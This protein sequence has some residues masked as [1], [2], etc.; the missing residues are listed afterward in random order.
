MQAVSA[1][2][3]AANDLGLRCVA[4]REANRVSINQETER[5]WET[6]GNRQ[7]GQKLGYDRKFYG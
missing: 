3:G 6:T 4:R 2:H 1:A 7:T 5:G